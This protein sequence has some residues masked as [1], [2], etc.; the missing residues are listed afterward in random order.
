MPPKTPQMAVPQENKV[1][2]EVALWARSICYSEIRSGEKKRERSSAPSFVLEEKP[3]PKSGANLQRTRKRSGNA[4]R[5]WAAAVVRKAMP[6]IVESLIEAAASLGEH[7]QTSQRNA[8]SHEPEEGGDE[9]LA[10]LLLRLLRT[11]EAGENSD[12]GTNAMTTV[13]EN[14]SVG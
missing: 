13:S 5:Q 9:S 3:L 7:S 1:F 6:K 10:A 4:H 8:S 12:A 14:P 2:R 11:P